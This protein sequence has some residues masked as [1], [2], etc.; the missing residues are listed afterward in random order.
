M[1]GL[2]IKGTLDGIDTEE[3]VMVIEGE[4]YGYDL[5]DDATFGPLDI[6][7]SWMEEYV[8][9]MVGAVVVDGVVKQIWRKE[10]W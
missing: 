2:Y 8:A 1:I 6:D 7:E 4:D 9:A 10:E 5:K 3:E